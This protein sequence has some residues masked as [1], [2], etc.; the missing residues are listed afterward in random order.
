M[1][2]IV[3]KQQLDEI[4]SLLTPHEAGLS[5]AELERACKAR[6]LKFD[7]RTLQRRLGQLIKTSRVVRQGGGRASR[8]RLAPLTGEANFGLPP[9]QLVAEGETYVPISAA[10]KEIRDYV[11]Q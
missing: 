4:S 9:I 7:R 11:R 6:G 1:P 8:Y 10:G 5:A 3:D 2:K